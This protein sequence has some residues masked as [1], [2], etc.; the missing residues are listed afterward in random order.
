VLVNKL[1]LRVILIV[2]YADVAAVFAFS[3]LR[4]PDLKLRFFCSIF[5]AGSVCDF[6]PKILRW[7]TR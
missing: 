6:V 5:Y 7:T 4:L 1:V 3:V 2:M